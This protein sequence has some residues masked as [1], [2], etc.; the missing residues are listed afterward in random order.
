MTRRSLS[1]AESR[2]AAEA[3]AFATAHCLA[4]LEAFAATYRE[5]GMTTSAAAIESAIKHLWGSDLALLTE[6]AS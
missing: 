3:S 2:L 6:T 1:A 4:V 5:N